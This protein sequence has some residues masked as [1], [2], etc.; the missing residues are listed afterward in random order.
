M[1]DHVSLGSAKLEEAIQFYSDCFLPLGYQLEHRTPE[2]A[3]FGPHGKWTFWLYP[4][5]SNE[6]VVGARSHV[7]LSAD[8]QEKI[9]RFHEVA[10]R[11]GASTVRAPGGRRDIS[12]DYFG[13]VIRD[14][15]GHTIEVVCWSK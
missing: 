11:R 14:L 13:T 1:I 8:T 12:P 10:L 9:V 6:A 4:V 3:A 2:E 5:P 15:D 7:A